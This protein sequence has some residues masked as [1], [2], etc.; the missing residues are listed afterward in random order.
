MDLE[1]VRGRV[2]CSL[3]ERTDGPA[4]AFA[5]GLGVSKLGRETERALWRVTG[6]GARLN[7]LVEELWRCGGK[8]ALSVA[9]DTEADR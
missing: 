3:S 4:D 8:E 2:G 7:S 6:S 9:R 5:I 1:R